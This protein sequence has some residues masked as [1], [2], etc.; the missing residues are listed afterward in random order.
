MQE[1]LRLLEKRG[2]VLTL[3][4]AE[5]LSLQ[6][7]AI[8]KAVEKEPVLVKAYGDDAPPTLTLV[9]LVRRI[10]QHSEWMGVPL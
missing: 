9:D 8:T 6:V 4:K 7:R 10:T 5:Y 2:N 1:R 3:G